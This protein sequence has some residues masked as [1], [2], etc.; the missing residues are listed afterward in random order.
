[1]HIEPTKEQVEGLVAAA[2]ESDGPV[3]MV[4]LLKFDDQGGRASYERYAVEVQP[5]L[6]RVGAT[7]IYAGDRH[8]VVI[9]GDQDGWWDTVLLVRYP[10]RA[11]FLE[12]ALDPD[13]QAV[14][15]HRTA[16]LT[17]SAL[18]STEPWM[19]MR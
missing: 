15:A 4:N 5:H 13:Y 9:G 11:K 8:Q 17:T 2:G 3:V 6:D 16:A 18:V 12:M 1:M 14:V 7:V 19:P 10:S